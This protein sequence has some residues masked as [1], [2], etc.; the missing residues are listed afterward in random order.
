LQASD[1]KL[2]ERNNLLSDSLLQKG[3]LYVKEGGNYLIKGFSGN[4]YY[5]KNADSF[6][7][8]YQQQYV[9]ES[10]ANLFLTQLFDNHPV[11]MSIKI[12][13]YGEDKATINT[14]VM[15][16]LSHFDASYQL[17]V[18]IEE[19]ENDHI[20]GSLIL[21]NPVLNFIHLIDMKTTPANLFG[22][23]QNQI[24]AVMY[25][26]IPCHNIRDLFYKEDNGKSITIDDIL[27]ENDNE[28]K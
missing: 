16:F 8:V 22:N 26:F 6:L 28:K 2:T 21:Y 24:S 15:Q 3:D 17:Y 25:P 14:S 10:F 5:R 7:P 13:S 23:G 27:L 9:K 12:K 1:N 18:G 11:S 4:T 19:F 20:R